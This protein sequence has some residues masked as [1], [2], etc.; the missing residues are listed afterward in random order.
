MYKN[1]SAQ[2]SDENKN[3]VI[4]KLRE[5]TTALPFLINLSPDE[6]RAIPNMGRK[7][8]KFVESAVGYAEKYPEIAPPYLDVQEQRKD[9]ELTKQLY[10][11]LEILEPLCEKIQD[12][13]FA[14]GAE[15]YKAGRI[16]YDS[17]KNATKADVPGIDAIYKDLSQNFEKT[18]P[19]KPKVAEEKENQS[20]SASADT[21]GA[22]SSE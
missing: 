18:S 7:S 19:Q 2:L 13:C 12:T 11:V 10:D 8:L 22:K 15:A 16:F 5:I 20:E 14:V 9:L 21:K 17:V 6:R 1:I 4:E 3:Q